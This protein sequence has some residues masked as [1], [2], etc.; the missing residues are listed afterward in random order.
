[1][2][3]K[4]ILLRS[5]SLRKSAITSIRQHNVRKRIYS[6]EREKQEGAQKSSLLRALT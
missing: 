6:N 5:K 4:S 1:M 3:I 2:S